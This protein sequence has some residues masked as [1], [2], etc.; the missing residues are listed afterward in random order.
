MGSEDF[1][2]YA[3]KVPGTMIF[4]GVGNPKKGKVHFLHHSEF[5]ID[6]DAL[7]VGMAAVAYSAYRFLAARKGVERGEDR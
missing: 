2:Y 4:V 1:A 3:E 6:E 7:K 5:D